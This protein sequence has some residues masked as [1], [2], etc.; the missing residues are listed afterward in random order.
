MMRLIVISF[1]A[2]RDSVTSRQKVR[3]LWGFGAH[4]SNFCCA[5]KVQMVRTKTG[6]AAHQNGK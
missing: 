4:R 1:S 5:P 3:I 6:G 2:G